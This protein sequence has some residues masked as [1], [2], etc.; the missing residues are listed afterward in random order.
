KAMASRSGLLISLSGI[1]G[2]GK[3]TI[4]RQL[5]EYFSS[6]YDLPSSVLWCKFGAHPLSKLHVSDSIKRASF[7]ALH[8]LS[9]PV[10][11]ERGGRGVSE[12]S[13]GAP[14]PQI[15]ARTLLLIH[16]AHIFFAVRQKLLRGEWIICDRYIFD[17]A[18]DLQQGF[19]YSSEKIRDILSIKWLPV[20]DFKFWLDLP[21]KSAY[22]RKPDTESVQFLR[23]RRALYTG[24]AQEFD[25]HMIDAS[26]GLDLVFNQMIEIIEEK[27]Y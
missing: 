23:E 11:G 13:F 4:A 16:L 22:R 21:E 5:Q 7:P 17:T 25:L 26:W 1:D 9:L 14:F 2:C 19:Q 12:G 10:L 3:S 24:I 6:E 27:C 20:P 8:P 15:Y 18:V